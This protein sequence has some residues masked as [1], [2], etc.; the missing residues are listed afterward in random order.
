[1]VAKLKSVYIYEYAFGIRAIRAVFQPPCP[2]GE[3]D[4]LK[5]VIIYCQPG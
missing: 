4:V 3:Q 5:L 1:M 2:A